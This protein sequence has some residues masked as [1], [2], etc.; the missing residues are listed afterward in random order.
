M[1][2]SDTPFGLKPAKYLSG[3]PYNGAC[4]IY[5]TASGDGT[6]IGIGDPVTYAGTTT[7]T[8]DGRI[9][10]DVKRAATGEIIV[11]VMVGV[12]PTNRDSTI[13]RAASTAT[14]IKVAD[15]PNLVFEIQEVSGGTALTAADIGLNADFVVAAASTTTG[16]SGVELNNGTEAATNTLDLLI[17]GFVNRADNAIGEHAKWY[18]RLNKHQFVDQKVGK[19]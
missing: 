16:M 13:Y 14:L 2:N 19:A 15:D 6:L 1:A 8:A 17:T 7:T 18:V 12:V 3:A 4:N 9:Y 10:P 5:G 11:G